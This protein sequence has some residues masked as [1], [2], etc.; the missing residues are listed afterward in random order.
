MQ[1]QGQSYKETI[2]AKLNFSFSNNSPNETDT[3][4]ASALKNGDLMVFTPNARKGAMDF[5]LILLND[6]VCCI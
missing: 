6:S 1:S 2:F 3:I 5:I 4:D